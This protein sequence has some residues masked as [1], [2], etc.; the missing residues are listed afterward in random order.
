LSSAIADGLLP[1]TPLADAAPRSPRRPRRWEGSR[2][3]HQLQI[4]TA[5]DDS[6]ITAKQFHRER[7]KS[8]R[9]RL[10][11]HGDRRMGR[12]RGVGDEEEVYRYV[13]QHLRQ[14]TP[15]PTGRNLAGHEAALPYLRL[16]REHLEAREHGQ[17]Q[18]R[19]TTLRHHDGDRCPE[20]TRPEPQ[21]LHS[22]SPRRC[23]RARRERRPRVARLRDYR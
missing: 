6:A 15:A 11:P 4:A 16:A 3:E 18:Q 14:P 9:H 7:G 20:R 12:R 22:L 2:A 23:L 8:W 13:R 21:W 19:D 1:R 17:A 5:S 10:E